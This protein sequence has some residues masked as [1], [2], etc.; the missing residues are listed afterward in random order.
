MSR[1]KK[2]K[3]A[4]PNA[5][6]D[7]TLAAERARADSILA[8]IDRQNALKAKYAAKIE[9]EIRLLQMRSALRTG[10]PFPGKGEPLTNEGLEGP[11]MDE[12]WKLVVEDYTPGSGPP[13]IQIPGGEVTFDFPPEAKVDAA[14]DMRD[15]ITMTEAARRAGAEVPTIGKKIEAGIVKDNGAKRTSR[16][17][18]PVS[19]DLAILKGKLKAKAGTVKDVQAR[20]EQDARSRFNGY[21]SERQAR[22][23]KAWKSVEDVAEIAAEK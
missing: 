15:W 16:R 10:K 23:A 8:E 7:D 13:P 12:F 20:V 5:I 1:R 18:D 9:E 3:H 4:E 19:L 21:S 11:E 2:N 22:A 14:D 6:R 17:V